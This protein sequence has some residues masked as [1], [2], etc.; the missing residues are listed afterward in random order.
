MG[1]VGKADI[2]V[3]ACHLCGVLY[4]IQFSSLRT[5]D[6]LKSSTRT[7]FLCKEAENVEEKPV[8]MVLNTETLPPH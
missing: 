5:K 7:H 4:Q 6:F 3:V 1:G 2:A 8:P